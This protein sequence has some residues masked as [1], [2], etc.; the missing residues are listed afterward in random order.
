M[1]LVQFDLAYRVLAITDS[2]EE[3]TT[4][5]VALKKTRFEWAPFVKCTYSE[6]RLINW[7][8]L[9]LGPFSPAGP[10]AVAYDFT[11]SA[12][13]YMYRGKLCSHC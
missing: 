2:S 1:S 9:V 4:G 7:G 10:I 11:K 3:E 6:I 12:S 5:Y 13:I 8:T